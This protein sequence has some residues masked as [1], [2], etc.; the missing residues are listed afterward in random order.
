MLQLTVDA[1]MA[2]MLQLAVEVTKRALLKLAADAT[3]YAEKGLAVETT[4]CNALKLAIDK[5]AAMKISDGLLEY[6]VVEQVTDVIEL[7]VLALAA[8]IVEKL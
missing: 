8:I 7:D 1:T 3:E 2:V 4:G 6:V 5:K